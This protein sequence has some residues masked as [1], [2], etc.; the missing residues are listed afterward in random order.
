MPS[1]IAGPFKIVSI[2]GGTVVFGDTGF[3]APKSAS[4]SYSGSGGGFTGDFSFSINGLNYTITV[5]PDLIDDNTN[6]VT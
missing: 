6:S 5:D 1:F 3:V 4:K 2:S